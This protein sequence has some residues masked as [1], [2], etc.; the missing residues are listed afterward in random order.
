M[1]STTKTQTSHSTKFSPLIIMDERERGEIRSIFKTIP[2]Q[3]RIKTLDVVDYIISKEIAIE[4]KRGD[5]LVASICDN[6]FFS[7]IVKLKKYYKKPLIILEN[8][9]KMFDR[10]GVYEASIYGAILYAIYKM[11]IALFP[12]RD[13]KETAET[14]WSFA[15]FVQKSEIFEY[16][17]IKVEQEKISVDSQLFFLEGLFQVSEKKAKI[18]LD[19]FK[20][21]YN[22]LQAITQTEISYTKSGK[23][24]GISGRLEE[25]KGFGHKFLSANHDL[26]K[27][28]FNDFK[29]KLN[30]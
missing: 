7:Q 14:I 19:H 11:K 28:P 8:P 5:D 17:P 21:P 3:L 6:R 9:K 20:T 22:V 27:K 13:A 30:L 24:K 15:K 2:C 29:N 10:K 18:L 26:L 23:P 16:E 1:Q 25:L 4:R 12:T